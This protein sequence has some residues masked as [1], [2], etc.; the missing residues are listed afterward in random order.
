M[1]RK[2]VNYEE[3]LPQVPFTDTPIPKRIHQIFLGKPAHLLPEEIQGNMQHLQSLNP[4][5]E[6]HLWS[7][8]DVEP[9]IL[10]Y[11]NEEVLRYF[12]MVSPMYRAAQADFLRYLIIYTLGGVYLDIKSTILEPLDETLLPSDRNIIYHWNNEV[13]GPYK[14]YGFYPDLPRDR[15]PYGEFPQTFII[16]SPGHPILRAVILDVMRNLDSYSPF[17]TDVGLW[18]VL[19]TTGPIAYSLAVERVTRELPDH[20]YRHIR[21]IEDIGMRVSIYGTATGHRKAVPRYNN[22]LTAVSLN[23]S[24]KYTKYLYGFFFGRRV[25]RI[26]RDKVNMALR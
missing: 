26:L 8:E 17:R 25:F 1:S 6:Y 14:G 16:S 7:D 22:L 20:L 15:F 18:G 12:R 3:I 24:E 10:E 21:C 9:F 4:D 11:Y 5:W 23:G 13:E 2:A 19:R